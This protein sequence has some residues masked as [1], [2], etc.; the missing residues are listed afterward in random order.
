M[1][2]YG[3]NC[4]LFKFDINIQNAYKIVP[5]H[6]SDWELLGFT[7]DQDFC[8]DKLFQWGLV[9]LIIYLRSSARQYTG[10]AKTSWESAGN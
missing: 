2:K 4:G 10:F 3:K 8:V 7:L 9:I 1:L 5:I 6:Y